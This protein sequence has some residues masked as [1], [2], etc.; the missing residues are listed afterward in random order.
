MAVTVI[1]RL[2]FSLLFSGGV[3]VRS[4][5][6][7][8]VKFHVPLPLF[9][10]ADNMAPSG[11]PEMVMLT[12]SSSPSAAAAI[13]S[14]IASSSKP[15]ASCSSKLGVSATAFMSTLITPLTTDTPCPLAVSSASAS[16]VVA[17]T[18]NEKSVSTPSGNDTPKPVSCAGVRVTVPSVMVIASP[19]VFDNT[20][21]SGR[22]E[23]S[24]ERVSEPSVSFSDTLI[25]SG[26]MV[27]SFALT[28]PTLRFASSATPAIAT[29]NEPVLV[30]NVPSCVVEVAVTSSVKAPE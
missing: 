18:N 14:G 29:F 16:V 25:S 11:T 5:S 3:I 4:A 21:P 6:S 19:A 13:S 7:S 24:I 1:S 27:F 22:L 17:V 26:T 9:T 28:S 20:A 30:A 8:V 10:P 23:I 12:I 2:K 15:A